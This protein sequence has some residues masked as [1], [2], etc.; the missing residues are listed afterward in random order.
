MKQLPL[1][2]GIGR[3]VMLSLLIA[4]IAVIPVGCKRGSTHVTE[5]REEPLE[6]ADLTEE[7]ELWADSVTSTLSLQKRIGQLF[8][9]AVFTTADAGNIALITDYAERLGVGG[10]VLLKGSAESATEIA[11]TLRIVSPLGLFMAIDAETGLGMR[12]DDAPEFLWNSEISASA[13][14]SVMYDYGREL[15]RE[16]RLAGINM[17]LGP[18]LDVDI[19]RS[20]SRKRNGRTFGND[21]ARVSKLGIA[22]SRGI[23][24]GGVLS[25]AKHFP[26]HGAAKG[27]SHKGLVTV[28]RDPLEF[29]SVD[30]LPFKEYIASG[31]SCVMVGHIH[32]PAL[33]SVVRPAS[34]SPV[35][36]TDLLRNKLGFT[37]LVLT[38]AVNMKGAKGY[39]ASEALKAGA[40]IILAPLYT[41]DSMVEVR[42]KVERGE[43]PESIITDRC[44]RVLFYKYLR[45]IAGSG[46][47]G[48]L[49]V[50]FTP[51]QL[52]HGA[53]TILVLLK[54]KN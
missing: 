14:E 4:V 35:I 52:H 42:D 54:G 16:C 41:E 33:D 30:L 15:A 28:G 27:D 18:V 9:P 53:D 11:D 40:D 38:D 23:E 13:D 24:S 45:G 51:A 1:S 49:R 26:G 3:I 39:T 37:G 34:F 31:L 29:S 10:L 22:Y 25:V 12:L 19:S 8:M 36:V 17:V 43:L 48:K 50:S 5:D 6:I 20:D 7:A 2:S 47:K 21:A 32:V 44:K 46:S